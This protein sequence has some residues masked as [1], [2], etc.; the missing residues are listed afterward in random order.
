[1]TQIVTLAVLAAL[2][3]GLYLEYR[4]APLAWVIAKYRK[5]VS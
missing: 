4:Y 1:M 5:V 3:G 2:G